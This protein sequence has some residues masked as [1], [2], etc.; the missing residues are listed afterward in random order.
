MDAGRFDRWTELLAR[1][2]SRRQSLASLGM[3]LGALVGRLNLVEAKKKRRKRRKRC[4]GSKRRCGKKCISSTRCCRG[5]CDEPGD[6]CTGGVCVVGQGTCPTGAD[7]C[8]AGVLCG[9]AA[10]P[11]CACFQSTAGETRCGDSA[12]LGTACD[13][14]TTDADCVAQ[15]PEV[16]GAF[17]FQGGSNCGCSAG[18]TF[19][20]APCPAH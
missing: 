16:P 14:C 18:Q 10:S 13:T 8:I 2:V 17:C 7:S 9:G 12:G 6:L 15:F 19:C 11:N 1:A 3:G 5:R 20:S 4:R